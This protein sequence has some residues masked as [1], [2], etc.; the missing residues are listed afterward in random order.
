MPC[1]LC[2]AIDA[3]SLITANETC[4]WMKEKVYEDMWILP[5]M[6]LFS[7]NPILKHYRSHPPGNS[8]ELYNI[9][10]CL[11]EDL[12]KAVDFCVRYT[13]SLHKL[14]PKTFSIENK[15]KGKSA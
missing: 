7:S 10:S 4:K 15:I 12:H 14:D 5:E 2:P 3:L 8:P 11:N 13:H 6:G 1:H 9:D